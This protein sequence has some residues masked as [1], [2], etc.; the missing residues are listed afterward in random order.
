MN[1]IAWNF[2]HINSRVILA[3]ATSGSTLRFADKVLGEPRVGRTT[4]KRYCSIV[5][6]VMIRGKT[7]SV[8]PAPTFREQTI[9]KSVI[10]IGKPFDINKV[11]ADNLVGLGSL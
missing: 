4:L 8:L 9:W 3:E 1:Y 11:F 7:A 6:S 10:C 5:E 2:T